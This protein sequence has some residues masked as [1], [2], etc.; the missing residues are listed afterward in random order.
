MGN[1]RNDRQSW[2]LRPCPP[3]DLLNEFDKPVNLVGQ[4]LLLCLSA[5]RISSLDV[6]SRKKSR[7]PGE[8][9]ICSHCA[10]LRQNCFYAEDLGGKGSSLISISRPESPAPP[11]SNTTLVRVQHAPLLDYSEMLND[12]LGRS[13]EVCGVAACRSSFQSIFS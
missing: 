2:A 12:F 9:P 11:Q 10:R 4:S 5:N 7:C 13:T 1:V 3:K 8:K 6:S